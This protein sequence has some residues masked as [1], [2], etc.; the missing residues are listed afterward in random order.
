MVWLVELEVQ[1]REV[2]HLVLQVV[3][4]HVLGYKLSEIL[5][6]DSDLIRDVGYHETAHFLGVGEGSR[7]HIRH[8]G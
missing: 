6:L 3:L 2:V 7:T 5:L 1:D 4:C 8:I